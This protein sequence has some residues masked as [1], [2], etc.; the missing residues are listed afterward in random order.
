MQFLGHGAKMRHKCIYKKD[1]S[2]LFGREAGC[3][4]VVVNPV[5]LE[6]IMDEIIESRYLFCPFCRMEIDYEEE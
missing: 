1:K 5:Q 4:G 2:S 6:R 3:C